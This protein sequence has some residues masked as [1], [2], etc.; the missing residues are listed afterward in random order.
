MSGDGTQAVCSEFGVWQKGAAA[1]VNVGTMFSVWQINS[2]NTQFCQSDPTGPGGQ[3]C[4]GHNSVGTSKMLDAESTAPANFR[5]L[6]N[7]LNFTS[8]APQ[9]TWSDH[10]HWPQWDQLDDYPYIQASYGLLSSQSSGCS[11]GVNYCPINAG[12]AITAIYPGNRRRIPSR[13]SSHDFRSHLHLRT[14]WS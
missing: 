2:A 9:N 5:S 1:G 13:S 14:A 6:S 11:N 10:G 7:V 3:Y 8:F 4:G 12:A